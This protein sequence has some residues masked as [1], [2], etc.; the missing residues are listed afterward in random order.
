MNKPQILISH[1]KDERF[2]MQKLL[3]EN[4]EIREAVSIQTEKAKIDEQLIEFK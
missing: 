3:S 4:R 1:S 2:S